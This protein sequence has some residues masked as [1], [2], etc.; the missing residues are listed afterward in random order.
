MSYEFRLPDVGE[1]LEEAE[2]VSWLVAEGDTVVRDQPLVEVQT[3][4]AVVELPSPVA[5]GVIRIAKLPGDM[6]KVG[7]LLVELDGASAASTPSRS[8]AARPEPAP[9]LE[10]AATSG[11]GGARAKAAPVVRRL[12]VELGVDLT[13]VPGSGPGGR[14][15]ADDVRR[16]ATAPSTEPMPLGDPGLLTTEPAAARPR[17]GQLSPGRHPLR[18]IRR[19]TA[20]TMALSWS[21]IPHIS[22]SDEIDAVPLLDAQRRLRDMAGERG[23]RLTLLAFF[24]RACATSLR[25]FPLVNASLDVEAGE[26]VVHEEVNIGLAVATDEG[27]VV[28]VLRGADR[29]GLLELAAEA[30]RLTEAA[31]QRSLSLDDMRGGTFTV[32]NYGS[33]GGRFANPIIRPPEAGIM[34][35]GA[36]RE[37][38]FVVDGQVLARPTLPY[39]FSA[40]HRL[41]DGDLSMAFSSDVVASLVDPLRLLLDA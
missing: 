35:F 19:R 7:D 41:I 16:F 39:S 36:I 4:K 17:L 5:G 28:P 21:T 34:G 2:I 15:L 30:S 9:V 24:V 31:R 29:L 38:P 14:V 33:L 12:A 3:D 32:T 13:T 6:V 11:N 26:I 37:R 27:L 40:D 23:G 20:E 1:G 22:S 18:G 10:R 25:R 8:V